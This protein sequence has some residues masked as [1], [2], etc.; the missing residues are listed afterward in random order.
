[1]G[2]Y[3]MI[4]FSELRRGVLAALA[5]VLAL[6]IA[7][8][9]PA[10]AQADGFAP[11]AFVNGR[12]ISQYELRQRILM[13]QLFRQPGEIHNLAMKSL[14]DDAL[15]RDA[16]KTLDVSVTPE[17]IK[18]G[19]V[20]FASRA[21]LPI[22]KFL[23]ALAQGGVDTETLRDFVEA[24]L[25]WRAVVRTKFGSSSLISDAEIDRAIAA[26]AASGGELRVLLA[27]IVLPSGGEV[28]AMALAQRLKKTST[29][30]RT[31]S[32]AA[33]DYSQSATAKA[34]GVL[35]WVPVSALP[36]EAASQIMA[37]KVG[38]VTDPIVMGGAVQ[39]FQLRDISQSAGDAKG[40]SV[41][42]YARFFAP[43]GSD[44][45]TMARTLDSCDDIY[46]LARG[47]AA[48]AVQRATVPES[49]LPADLRAAV[50]RLDPG[51]TAVVP[52]QGGA[53]SL[54]MLCSRA[55]GSEVTPSR[56]D[57]GGTLVNDKLGLL[58]TGYL[59]EL[60]SNAIIILK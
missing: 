10:M 12:A 19:M 49:G 22:E 30:T 14:I 9:L 7:V 24:G 15:R 18:G 34:G 28:D 17:E 35:G 40:A 45:A 5:L 11:A 54:V 52:G 53:A 23:K 4:F 21:N 1:M 56:A 48:E 55:P 27:E 39:L 13:M 38:E 58:A 46:D 32:M 37:L 8:P 33:Q 20:E 25:L 2:R 43:S 36:P 26:G 60:R 42:D 16:A 51:E 41:V 29:S 3:T 57:V 47:M 31:F 6:L 44:L 59:E 50:S